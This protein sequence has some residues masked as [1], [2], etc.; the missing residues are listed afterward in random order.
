[1]YT[2]SIAC[3]AGKR[4]RKK[5]N[6]LKEKREDVSYTPQSRRCAPRQGR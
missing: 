2:S 3:A 4:N 6:H 1:M 5:E